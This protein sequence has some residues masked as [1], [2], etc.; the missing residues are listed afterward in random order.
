MKTLC[1]FLTLM[2]GTRCA[3]YFGH[4][5]RKWAYFAR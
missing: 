5:F 1:V 3:G 2:E 4:L